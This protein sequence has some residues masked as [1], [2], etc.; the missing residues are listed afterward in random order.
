MSILENSKTAL[1]FA[2]WKLSPYA[3]QMLNA[4]TD[5][6]ICFMH[7]PKCGGTSIDEAI[8]IS[9]GLPKRLWGNRVV[10]LEA[11]ASLKASKLMGEDLM[12]FRSKL[13]TYHLS[14]PSCSYISGHFTYD[15]QIFEKFIDQWNFITVLRHPVSRWFSMYFYNHYKASNHFRIDDELESF[16][17]SQ[18]GLFFGREYVAKFTDNIP[19]EEASSQSAIYQAIE[20]LNRRFT[21]IGTIEQLDLFSQNFKA[22]FGTNLSIRKRNSNPLNKQKQKKMISD[23]IY[24]RVQDICQ[25]DLLVYE[26]IR[27]Q[28]SNS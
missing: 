23:K 22:Q 20:N 9:Y 7:I 26:A 16:V 2:R 14:R 3:R 25:P 24:E 18:E 5:A 21:L 27:E 15:E 4:T 17:K 1:R 19:I 12:D 10:R 11:I 13:L 6:K 8:Q 28:M